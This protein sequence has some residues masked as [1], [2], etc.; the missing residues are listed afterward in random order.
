TPARLR[1]DASTR[2]PE[3][4]LGAQV[5]LE[6]TLA[7]T[8]AEVRLKSED[9]VQRLSA[10]SLRFDQHHI[11]GTDLRWNTPAGWVRTSFE[12]RRGLRSL[13]LEA[14][15]FDLLKAAE[16]WELARD[17]PSGVV[18]ASVQFEHARQGPAGYL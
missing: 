14:H 7:V 8:D 2:K 5:E 18:S 11:A 4:E 6:P 15:R 1:V 9:S 17:L 16:P 10:A 3:L 13:H 12:Y